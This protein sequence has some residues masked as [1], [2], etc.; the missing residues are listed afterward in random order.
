MLNYAHKIQGERSTLYYSSHIKREW[1]KV[2]NKRAQPGNRSIQLA[3]NP[4]GPSNAGMTPEGAG[5]E[6]S[7]LTAMQVSRVWITQ[8]P[9]YLLD[10]CRVDG[11]DCLQSRCAAEM[12][13]VLLAEKMFPQAPASSAV[14]VALPSL[15]GKPKAGERCQQVSHCYR[16]CAHT[17]WFI[18]WA[19][20]K[21]Q[22]SSLRM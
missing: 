10:G 20:L 7:P 14:P 6:P 19:E 17:G 18:L 13:H 2:C 1:R 5:T 3:S 11:G 12:F 4:T 9:R 21:W 8:S 16:G 15:E 22:L